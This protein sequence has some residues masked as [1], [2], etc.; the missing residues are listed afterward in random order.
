MSVIDV[1]LSKFIDEERDLFETDDNNKLA[2]AFGQVMRYYDFLTIIKER[3]E[4]YNVRL[5]KN[6]EVRKTLFPIGTG[7]LLTGERA[8]WWEEHTKL[9]NCI[10]LEIE[11]YYLFA[12]ILLDKIA[13]FVEFFFGP[14]RNLSLDSHDQMTKCL[15]AYSGAKGLKDYEH[16]ENRL[17]S[18][19][20]DIADFRDYQIAHEKSPRTLHD[21]SFSGTGETAIV[22]TK[23]HPKDTDTE[24]QS[25]SLAKLEEDLQLYLRDIMSLIRANRDK[26]KLERKNVA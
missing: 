9:I 12:K 10:Q 25:K 15:R 5:H 24:I 17:K 14:E 2:I 26:S 20:T 4:T 7:G 23:F 1:E 11:S 6:L 16:L 8:V 18:L 22:A 3:Y 21:V 19:K 13:H